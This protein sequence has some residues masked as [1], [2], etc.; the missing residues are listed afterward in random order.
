MKL[1]KLKNLYNNNFGVILSNTV[2]SFVY[3]DNFLKYKTIPKLIIIYSKKNINQKI[4]KL[5]IKV[6]CNIKIIKSDNVNFTNIGKIALTSKIDNFIFSGY[7][8]EIVKNK[9]FLNKINLIHSHSGLIP[10]YMGSTT[11]YYSILNEKKIHCSTFV[12]NKDVD[13]GTILLIKRYNLPR[14]HKV[15]N[16]DHIIRAKNLISLINQKNKKINFNK[17][18]TKKNIVF[19]YKAHPVLRNL[20][21]KKLI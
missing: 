11:I 17:K 8:G 20:A 4:K 3:L 12:M 7:P 2:R 18:I 5:L 9:I 6:D 10:K 1:K 16:Y 14:K 19:F 15:D 13:Q 21:N